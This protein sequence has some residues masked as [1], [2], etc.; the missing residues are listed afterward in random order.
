MY[1]VGLTFQFNV[2]I[3]LATFYW[4]F[5]NILYAVLI[6]IVMQKKI[7]SFQH[8]F[9]AVA[10]LHVKKWTISCKSPSKQPTFHMDCWEMM[11]QK[12]PS[13]LM[14]CSNRVTS[15]S[16]N[17]KLSFLLPLSEL[18][19]Q[20]WIRLEWRVQCHKTAHKRR[21]LVRE[22]SLNKSSTATRIILTWPPCWT[23]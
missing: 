17:E 11:S 8:L 19:H 5:K 3:L 16:D 15:K 7:I 12:K 23:V 6:I 21:V 4:F 14:Y 20:H 22:S 9:E 18:F 1:I 2:V 10:W 13:F